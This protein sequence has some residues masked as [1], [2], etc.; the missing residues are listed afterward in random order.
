MR[1]NSLCAGAV[2]ISIGGTLSASRACA[3]SWRISVVLKTES[4]RTVGVEL[5]TDGE[6]L[7]AFCAT[8]IDDFST[9]M[10]CHAF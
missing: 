7:S 5:L 6:T 3:K 8:T 1:P 2:R 10:G 4:D 9:I